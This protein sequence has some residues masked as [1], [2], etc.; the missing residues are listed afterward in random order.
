MTSSF[1]MFSKIG[2]AASVLSEGQRSELF[3]ALAEYGF[4]GTEPDGLPSELMAFFVLARDDIDNS[5]AMRSRGERGGRPSKNTQVAEVIEMPEPEVPET[6]EPE[7]SEPAE[8]EVSDT[9]EPQ[10]SDGAK[11]RVSGKAKPNPIQ[12]SPDQSSPDQ[13]RE[14]RASAARPRFRPPTVE[15]VRAYAEG[16]GCNVDAERFVDY[17]A[18]NGWKVGRSPMRDWRAA[19]R[20]WS[21][22]D[23]PK[24]A[25]SV[26]DVYSRL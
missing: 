15:D 17:Y 7:V 14:G 6:P 16:A 3:A 9:E 18:S 22:R 20:N 12:S 13:K 19:A 4:Y 1:T 8:P 21:R 5:K 2:E 23:A 10:V 11:P 25:T 24:E 26:G